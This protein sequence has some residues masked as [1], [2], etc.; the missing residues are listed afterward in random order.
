MGK[1]EKKT[2]LYVAYYA[3]V[4]LTIAFSVLFMVAMSLSN[5]AIYQQVVYYV[6]AIVLILTICFDIFATNINQLKF[7]SGLIVA[8]LNFLCLV[9]GIIVYGGMSI[10][11]MIPYYAG[12]RFAIVILFSTILSIMSIVVFCVG[13][14]LAEERIEKK[15]GK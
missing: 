12:Q 11:G 9:M 6:W 3:S 8:G 2:L 14:R 4:T 5:V 15:T 1:S 13:E 10:D 7:I